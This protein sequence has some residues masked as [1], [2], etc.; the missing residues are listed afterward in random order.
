MKLFLALLL[1]FSAQVFA[2]GPGGVGVSHAVLTPLVLD[3][4]GTNVTNAAYVTFSAALT[5]ACSAIQIHNTG[6]QPI[7]LAT[8]AAASEVDT[9]VIFPIGVSILVPHLLPKGVRLSV[10]S[11]G[12]TQSTGLLIFSCFQ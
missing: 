6:A 3:T 1:A 8:G 5:N 7:K 9:G 10:R 11:M 4:S 2:V 12:S